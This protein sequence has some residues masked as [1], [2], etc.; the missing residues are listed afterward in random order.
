MMIRRATRE[1]LPAIIQMGEKF[2]DTSG[3]GEIATYDPVSCEILGEQ[4]LAMGIILV[5][6]HHERLVGVIGV[7]LAPF[8]MNR[9]KLTAHEVL[10]YVEDG[11]RATGAGI[12]LLRAIA[13]ET[14]AAGAIALFML[15]LANSPPQAKLLYKRLGYRY[16]ESSYMKVL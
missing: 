6:E 13:K 3:Y 14:K 12:A 4:L 10:W 16:V 7:I 9:E 11:N 8:Q 2:F 15:H 5:A 1:D